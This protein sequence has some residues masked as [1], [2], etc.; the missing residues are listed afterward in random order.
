M[1]EFCVLKKKARRKEG[2]TKGG[3]GGRE[4][5]RKYWIPVDELHDVAMI[6]ALQY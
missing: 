4:K 2:R 1:T 6:S 3:E 5:E